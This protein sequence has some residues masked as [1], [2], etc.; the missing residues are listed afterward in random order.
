MNKSSGN[1]MQCKR[2]FSY[3]RTNSMNTIILEK[4]I[5]TQ[6]AKIIPVLYGTQKV[7]TIYLRRR[8][9]SVKWARRIQ[10]IHTKQ[11]LK[12]KFDIH[13]CIYA[14]FFPVISLPQVSTTINIESLPSP[15]PSTRPAPPPFIS[16]INFKTSTV[17][18]TSL[19]AN[20]PVTCFLLTLTPIPSKLNSQDPLSALLRQ[21]ERRISTHIQSDEQ[22][23]FSLYFN[24]YISKY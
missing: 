21:S 13:P 2:T 12:D 8:Q 6:L 9:V 23:Y 18:E 20:P 14:Y 5:V 11:C 10:S 19:Y 3:D 7:I 16:L 17:H 22:N 1:K 15:I 4:I 24:L